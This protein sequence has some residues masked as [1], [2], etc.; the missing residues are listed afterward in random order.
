MVQRLGCRA[1]TEAQIIERGEADRGDRGGTSLSN[2]RLGVTRLAE[3]AI[4]MVLHS[5]TQTTRISRSET[6]EQKHRGE[7]EDVV[8]LVVP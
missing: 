5:E 4:Y 3:P 2:W 6:L 7:W 8:E 1:L